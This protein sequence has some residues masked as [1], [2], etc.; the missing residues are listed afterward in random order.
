M[1]RDD[2]GLTHS[3]PPLAAWGAGLIQIALGAGILTAPDRGAHVAAIALVLVGAG[4]L[5]WGV[6]RLAGRALPGVGL[7]VALLGIVASAFALF[8]DPVRT[9]VLAVVVAVALDTVIGVAVG[10]ARRTRRPR[11]RRA[12]SPRAGV[13][14]LLVG[15][16]VVAGAVTPALG[17]TEAGRLAPVHGSHGI[18]F[19][20]PHGH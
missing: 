5:V 2:A 4:S 16:I 20:G 15:A 11:T 3:W 17:A 7:G 13:W 14:G 6:L 18:E 12:P 1:A 19:V 9:S 10:T 8:L